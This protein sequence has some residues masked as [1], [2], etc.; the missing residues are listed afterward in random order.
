MISFERCKFFDK[1]SYVSFEIN[2]SEKP[3]YEKIY[4]LI[5]GSN[6]LSYMKKN[7]EEEEDIK[8][9]KRLIKGTSDHVHHIS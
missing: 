5:D 2:F 3:T 8:S 1:Q 9:S 4:E 6:S 7:K